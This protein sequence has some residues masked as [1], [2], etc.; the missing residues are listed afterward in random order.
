MEL[1]KTIENQLPQVDLQ[2]ISDKAL[3]MAGHLNALAIT[4][5]NATSLEDLRT[6]AN[7]FI[8]GTKDSLKEAKEAFLEPFNAVEQKVLEAIKPLELE[9][10]DFSAKI[11]EVKKAKRYKEAKCYY[12]S[13]I[14]PNEDGEM[15][16]AEIPNFDSIY[17]EIPQ[18]ASKETIHRYIENALELAQ[19]TTA[20]VELKGSRNALLQ[21]RQYAQSLKIDWTLKD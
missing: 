3:E 4:E 9:N 15:P 16:Y 19:K 14:A 8:K 20:N 1:I 12:D 2:A 13:L 18:S 5:D 7:K 10:K 11:L 21:L 6:Q 17:L